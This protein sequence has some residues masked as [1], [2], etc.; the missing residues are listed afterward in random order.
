[1]V[2]APELDM[3]QVL[4]KHIQ[5]I[6]LRDGLLTGP[7]KSSTKGVHLKHFCN[8]FNLDL[9]PG[10]VFD[11]LIFEVLLLVQ[12]FFFWIY[13]WDH[14]FCNPLHPNPRQQEQGRREGKRGSHAWAY[15][16]GIIR[17]EGFSLLLAPATETA[18]QIEKGRQDSGLLDC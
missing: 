9:G 12:D 17:A 4:Q 11:I 5:L 7:Q 2:P 16:A 8:F 1:M 18:P 14:Y 10:T 13:F 3:T 15:S 6:G